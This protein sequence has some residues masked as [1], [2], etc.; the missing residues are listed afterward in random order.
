MM[1][2]K[3]PG[4]SQIWTERTQKARRLIALGVVAILLAG[5][6][7]GPDYSRPQIP[8]TDVY[9]AEPLPQVTASTDAT[10][11]GQQKLLQGADVPREWWTLF[12]SAPEC[13]RRCICSRCRHY[14]ARRSASSKI[15]RAGSLI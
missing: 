10:G 2:Q 6:A 5:C 8:K 15:L 13:L 14:A 4:K 3:Y 12:Q 11:G 1:D 7:V 9:Q